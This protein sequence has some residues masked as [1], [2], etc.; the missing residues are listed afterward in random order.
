MIEIISRHPELVSGSNI[1]R[2]L[3]SLDADLSTELEMTKFSMTIFSKM[4]FY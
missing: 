4:S 3:T 2:D 1:V